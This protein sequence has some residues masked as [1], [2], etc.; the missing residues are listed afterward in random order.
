MLNKFY[1]KGDRV[2]VA[3]GA[4]AAGK[5]AQTKRT[6]L[7]KQEFLEA[8]G[9]KQ[10]G[11]LDNNKKF[12]SSIRAMAEQTAMIATNQAIRINAINN[13][14]SAMNIV[15]LVGD[16]KSGGMFSARVKGPKKKQVVLNTIGK[17]DRG[18]SV[19]DKILFWEGLSKVVEKAVLQNNVSSIEAAIREE[20][21]DNPLYALWPNYA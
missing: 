1:V 11:T 15:A 7:T 14:S 19:F 9:I 13:E 10:D 6:D 5:F 18:L 21:S 20:F 4:T 16:G 8:F 3:E 2:R 12:D 17:I